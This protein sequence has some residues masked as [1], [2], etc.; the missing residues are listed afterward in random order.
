MHHSSVDDRQ[1]CPPPHAMEDREGRSDGIIGPKSP[2][3]AAC[4]Q[5]HERT[6][7]NLALT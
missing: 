5:K 1:D 4:V 3:L 2:V 6:T 7:A